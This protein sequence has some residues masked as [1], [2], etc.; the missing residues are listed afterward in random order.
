MNVFIVEDEDLYADQ[1]VMLV[2][3]AGHTVCGIATNA[4]EALRLFE[5]SDADMALIDINLAGEMDG[6]ELGKWLKRFK[7]DILII[8]ITAHYADVEYFERAK[9]LSAYAFLKKPIDV[10]DLLRTIE[11][12]FQYNTTQAD[13]G[14]QGHMHDHHTLLVKIKAKYIKID[15][16]DIT[17]I[18]AEDKYCSIH[19]KDGTVYLERISLNELNKKLSPR[20][21]A[22]TH[23]SYIVNLNNVQETDTAEFTIK[24]SGHRVPL[25]DTYKTYFL[26]KFG[27]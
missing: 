6:L 2:E 25:G 24:V 8:F 12:A 4:E 1:L 21:F 16:N 11:L 10:T 22:R 13:I 23:R 19:L 26:K 7:D 14:T 20:L 27:A 9:Q 18:A 17:H 15:Q 3:R 5:K